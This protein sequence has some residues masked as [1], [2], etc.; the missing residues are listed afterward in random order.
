LQ[1]LAIKEVIKRQGLEAGGSAQVAVAHFI[2][3]RLPFFSHQPGEA[4]NEGG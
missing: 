1:P 4:G 2:K 3:Y